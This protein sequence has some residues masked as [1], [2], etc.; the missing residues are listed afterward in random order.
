[1]KSSTSIASLIAAAVVSSS[2]RPKGSDL[3]IQT[4]FVPRYEIE[5]NV[6]IFGKSRYDYPTVNFTTY[7]KDVLTKRLDGCHVVLK[8]KNRW[9][10][11]AV[12]F[13]SE[14]IVGG[15]D[16]KGELGLR[17]RQGRK[18]GVRWTP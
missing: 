2:K 14:C 17:D 6:A 7:K 1:M 3:G 16:L 10:R 13:R 5:I 9:H 11:I 12:F 8:V 15:N 4:L 18:I